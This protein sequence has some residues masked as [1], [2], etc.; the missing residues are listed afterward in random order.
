MSKN[1]ILYRQMLAARESKLNNSMYN[2]INFIALC[3]DVEDILADNSR[4][5]IVT[6]SPL[7][8]YLTSTK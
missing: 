7:R 3:V 5:T 4:N 8:H 6:N 1:R 2:R